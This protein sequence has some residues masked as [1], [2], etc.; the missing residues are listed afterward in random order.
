MRINKNYGLKDSIKPEKYI[1]SGT[2]AIEK[3]VVNEAS[4]APYCGAISY[5]CA[6]I[7]QFVAVGRAASSVKR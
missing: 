3:T 4:F 2:V 7:A 1:I 6:Y 5:F